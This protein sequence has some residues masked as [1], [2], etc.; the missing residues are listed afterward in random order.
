MKIACHFRVIYF[1][2]QVIEAILLC[3][4]LALKSFPLFTIDSS[5]NLF[6]QLFNLYDWRLQ[7][8]FF[9]WPTGFT[10]LITRLLRLLK[11]PLERMY[12]Q[13]EVSNRLRRIFFFFY[14]R[15]SVEA[16]LWFF[17]DTVGT[18]REGLVAPKADIIKAALFKILH[19]LIWLLISC[20]KIITIRLLN[21]TKINSMLRCIDG[22]E[23][24]SRRFIKVLT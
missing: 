24:I 15:R 21:P 8:T 14:C 13:P 23:Y 6:L 19:L 10:F 4:D 22:A 16:L 9:A 12:G 5:I 2:F 20:V 3:W 7:L 18:G 11:G 17:F 1:K